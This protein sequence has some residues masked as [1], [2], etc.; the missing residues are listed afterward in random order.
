MAD[1]KLDVSLFYGRLNLL[2]Q[3]WKDANEPDGEKLQSTGGILLVAGNTDDSNPYKKTGALQTFLLGYEFPS[4]LTFITHDSVIFLC[5]ESK[6]KILNSLVKP[7]SD[8]LS[9]NLN[10]DV[11]VIV[12][13]KDSAAATSAMETVLASI[14]DVVSQDKKIGRLV[15]DKYTG[16][17]VDE[18]NS[19][20]KTKGKEDLIEQASDVSPAVS[21]ILAV[22][23]AQE[24]EYTEVACKMAQKLMSV[25]CNQMTNLIE[26]E[27]KITHEKLAD[28]I[29]G[30]LEDVNVWQGAKY[31]PDFDN[32]YA[33]LC[34]TP[35]IQSGG[36]YD[37]RTSAQSNSERL[38]DK[39]II[40]ASLGI[41]YKS[42]CSNVSRTIMIDPHPTQ[43]ANYNYLLE[44]QKFALG[45]LKEGIAANDFLNTVKSKVA[46]DRA[47]LESCL[48]K[49]FGFSLG[50]EFRDS[51]LTLSSKCTRILKQNMIFSLT[52][53]L[54]DIEDPFDSAKYYSLQLIDTVR[55][56]NERSTIL[57]DGLKE[58]S[59]IAFFFND[60]PSKSKNG[61]SQ[62]TGK[63]AS[64]SPNKSTHS[65]R[66][67]GAAV[68]TTSRK[69]RLR[70]D[71]KEIDNEATAKR[72]LHQKELAERRQEEGLSKY[73]EDDGTGKGSEVK[74][75][76]RFESFPRERDLP[77]AVASLRIIVDTNKRS[78][79]LPINGFAVP[80]HINTLKNVVKQEE[81]DYT[82]LRFMLVAPGQITGKKEDTPFEDP[83][84]TFIRGL[85]YRSTDNE[86][87]N[88]V[89]K[90]VT[91]LKKAVLKREKDQAEKADVV[92]QDQLIEIKTRRPIKMLDISVRPS[93]DGKR[94]AGD[95]EI[96]TNGIRYQ[97]TLRS[98]HRIDILFNNIKH[99]FFQPCDQELFVILHIHFKSPIF[100]GKKKT[101]DI[102]FFREA[103]EATFD[104]TGN[105]KR[106]RQNNGG[107][108]DEIEAEQDE[109]RK[110]SEL[111]KHFKSFADKIADASDGRLEV[112]MPFR[113]LGFQG[114]PFRSSV[115]LQPTTE[116]LVHLVEP[117]FLVV[118]LTEVEVAHLERIQYGLK[119]FDLVFVFKDF[120]KTPIHINTIPSGQI[121]NVKEW[122]DSCDIPFSEGPV[123]LNWS[124]IMKTVTDDPYEFFKEGGWSFLN[125]QSDEEDEDGHSD[126]E[127]S[128][129]EVS[130]GV[131]GSSSDDS[132]SGSDFDEDASD[133]SG[134]S[135]GS[136]EAS[137]SGSEALDW[138]DQEKRAARADQ[139]KKKG[140]GESSSNTK[141]PRG[142]EPSDDSDSDVSIDSE[143]EAKKQK[144]KKAPARK[145]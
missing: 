56:G 44:L 73:A 89:Y 15:K 2:I 33:D 6:A 123:N 80:F 104:E 4:T 140:A 26:T 18:W 46:A 121:E 111:N 102:Q 41:R 75:W 62:T 127:D 119:N 113:E 86:H 52:I 59:H 122:I 106:R 49:S 3:S 110:R 42:Y 94:Q 5:S 77:S 66:K 84:A 29:E 34:Y 28:L 9:G 67:A 14:E 90:K 45:E 101:K 129:F 87:M 118:T 70:N 64:A 58:L 23:D 16:K 7:S 133:S 78:F 125:S 69:G 39:G 35:I 85:T 12:K 134:G 97:S 107:D 72:K 103:S 124:A 137:G 74:Q 19:F 22:K 120:T 112:D 115:L 109:R 99:I 130:D 139:K 27:K 138:S 126:D 131:Y 60:K 30:K 1:V 116:C 61:K 51:F 43:E 91:D 13:P 105:R 95:V 93:F 8:Q 142:R 132:D 47:E 108:E 76:K 141:K 144:K 24:R 136:A 40:L 36:E 96:H 98:D 63:P 17:F 55:V 25:M 88:E 53:S 11:Q 82:V 54:A 100:I 37:L 71:G 57:C 79:I 21:L 50:I 38:K 10:I 32:T 83:N 20:L 114:V 65:P 143:E 48:P 128:A 31:A 117:P 145:R 135:S 81:G 68:V 92:D